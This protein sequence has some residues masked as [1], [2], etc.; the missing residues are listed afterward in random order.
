MVTVANDDRIDGSVFDEIVE[1]EPFPTGQLRVDTGIEEESVVLKFD[2]PGTGTNVIAGIEICNSHS[3]RRLT[4]R[5]R[6]VVGAR[7]RFT[8]HTALL[9]VDG[10]I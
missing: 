7:Q 2:V 3:M 6:A 10:G 4:G 5:V 1:R 9:T 8:S